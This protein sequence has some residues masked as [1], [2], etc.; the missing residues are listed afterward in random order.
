M[1]SL[2]IRA[3]PPARLAL[4]MQLLRFGIVGTCGFATTTAVVY[5]TRPWIG[6][7][8]AIVPGFALAVTVTWLLNRHWTFRG[9]GSRA[10][11]LHREWAAFVAANLLGFLLNASVYWA[12]IAAS[13]LCAANP[14]LALVAGTLVGM[15][16][17]FVLSRQLVFR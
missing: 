5:A 7:Y 9:H 4:A 2:L 1:I 15:G 14:V 12:L 11:P 13:P 10:R 8:L 16:V 3:L 17:N 6:D